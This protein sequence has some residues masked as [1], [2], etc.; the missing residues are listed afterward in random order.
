MRFS[1]IL[2]AILFGA[3]TLFAFGCG[4][5][6]TEAD[7]GDPAVDLS[8]GTEETIQDVEEPIE[9][10]FEEGAEEVDEELDEEPGMDDDY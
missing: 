6:E 2:A 9:E 5:S 10:P 7:E 3:S 8:Q 1:S 4:G